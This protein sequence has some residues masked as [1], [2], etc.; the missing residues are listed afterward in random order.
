VTA[1]GLQGAGRAIVDTR[2]RGS[3]QGCRRSQGGGVLCA[4]GLEADADDRSWAVDCLEAQT[5]RI[6]GI[7]LRQGATPCAGT[8]PTGGWANEFGHEVEGESAGVP[9]LPGRRSRVCT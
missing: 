5:S 6:G 3:R 2:P 8:R 4:H 1:H 9:T 7:N